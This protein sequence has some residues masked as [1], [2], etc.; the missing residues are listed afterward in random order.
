[1]NKLQDPKLIRFNGAILYT[2]SGESILEHDGI[3]ANFNNSFALEWII[4]LWMQ[5]CF[6]CRKFGS[7]IQ[8]ILFHGDLSFSFI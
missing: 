7:S 2:T 6:R 5:L 3:T 4:R 8:C 1:M